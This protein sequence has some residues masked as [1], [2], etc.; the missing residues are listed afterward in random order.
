MPTLAPVTLPIHPPPIETTAVN[1]GVAVVV[2]LAA[3]VC[4][5]KAH[6]KVATSP[7]ATANSPYLPADTPDWL[8]LLTGICSISITLQDSIALVFSY[9]HFIPTV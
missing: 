2:A 1:E 6:F 3:G 9:W 4:D 8:P 7:T 5:A